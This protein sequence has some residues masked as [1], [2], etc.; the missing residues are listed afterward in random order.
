MPDRKSYTE[1]WL[2]V[3][4]LRL[5]ATQEAVVA[6][7][8]AAALGIASL[9]DGFA[10]RHQE[11]F[12]PEVVA[13]QRRDAHAAVERHRDEFRDGAAAAKVAWDARGGVPVHPRFAAR[14]E[15]GPGIAA[16]AP[17]GA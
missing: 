11:A 3:Q 15:Q 10:E 6:E 14:N 2:A 8:A 12:A 17:S 13:D 7:W 1:E 9:G 16:E 4:A 5:T